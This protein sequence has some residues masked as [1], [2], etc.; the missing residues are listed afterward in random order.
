[1]KRLFLIAVLLALNT[2]CDSFTTSDPLYVAA[3]RARLQ[4]VGPWLNTYAAEHSNNAQNVADVVSS[5]R[6]EIEAQSRHQAA[7][8]QPVK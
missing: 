8:T 5:W 3:N 4:A 1:M 6:Q 2:G 7:A